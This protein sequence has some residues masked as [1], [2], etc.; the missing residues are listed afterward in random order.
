MNIVDETY[1][2]NP[3]VASK[4]KE[5][6]DLELIS[7]AEKI[8][9][10]KY[11]DINNFDKAIKRIKKWIV[12]NSTR[13]P[14][15]IKMLSDLIRK[16][17]NLSSLKDVESHFLQST[18]SF[19]STYITSPLD[20]RQVELRR[21]NIHI[22]SVIKQFNLQ[23]TAANVHDNIQDN[24]ARISGNIQDRI[25]EFHDN[26][27]D[28]L[29]RFHDG[30][31]ERRDARRQKKALEKRTLEQ[32]TKVNSSRERVNGNRA[33]EIIEKGEMDWLESLFWDNAK[34]AKEYL[35]RFP[36]GS[37]AKRNFIN[38]LVHFV[39]NDHTNIDVRTLITGAFQQG[40]VQVSRL[41]QLRTLTEN[42][43][44]NAKLK[45]TKRDKY[46]RRV[47]W[48]KE[49]KSIDSKNRWSTSKVSENLDGKDENLRD[50]VTSWSKIDTEIWSEWLT[51]KQAFV[52]LN[53][54]WIE[55]LHE[56]TDEELENKYNEWKN[57]RLNNIKQVLNYDDL[58][59]YATRKQIEFANFD[60]TTTQNYT[61]W[62]ERHPDINNDENKESQS[63]KKFLG[64]TQW[65]LV[66]ELVMNVDMNTSD[67]L[68]LLQI[69][70]MSTAKGLKLF[71]MDHITWEWNAETQYFL[72]TTLND[73]SFQASDT[74]WDYS[75]KILEILNSHPHLDTSYLDQ[76]FHT[77][78]EV[79]NREAEFLKNPD[80]FWQ[81]QT[82]E[83]PRE[84]VW[85]SDSWYRDSYKL[86]EQAFLNSHM[87]EFNGKLAE[88]LKIPQIKEW[89]PID[90]TS[91]TKM[92]QIW[93]TIPLDQINAIYNLFA[94]KPEEQEKFNNFL[95]DNNFQN[96]DIN[97]ISLKKLVLDQDYSF[98]P[99]AKYC[100]ERIW[101]S[102]Q[103]EITSESW[104]TLQY[105][106]DK[107]W[108]TALNIK[109][110]VLEFFLPGIS[111]RPEKAENGIFYFRDENNL[112]TLYSFDPENWEISQQGNI[113]LEDE[114]IISFRSWWS[115]GNLLQKIQWFQNIVD[116]DLPDV[117]PD[118][119]PGNMEELENQILNKI[120]SKIAVEK[121]ADTSVVSKELLR[122]KN[123]RNVCHDGIVWDLKQLLNIEDD[124]LY[125]TGWE[126]Y[127]IFYNL[128]KTFER[129]DVEYPN[130]NKPLISMKLLLDKIC[131]STNGFKLLKPSLLEN[132]WDSTEEIPQENTD[133]ETQN[134][135]ETARGA[136]IIKNLID[137]S[138]QLFDVNL[139]DDLANNSEIDQYLAERKFDR[140]I[141][142]IQKNKE[143]KIAK[144][145]YEK[146]IAKLYSDT[147]DELHWL[148][149][150][151]E[152][153][154][155]I[156]SLENE[157][158]FLS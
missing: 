79:Q 48:V 5:R 55:K 33:R 24:I 69:L 68:K 27:Q 66:W 60:L 156:N 75:R 87:Q 57:N 13:R 117:L 64:F 28:N 100:Y 1:R 89:N 105:L 109:N 56:I 155:N 34:I 147:H 126:N 141:G 114:W 37:E 67:W 46:G 102:C 101:I 129:I 20:I 51:L 31:V 93:N 10:E 146:E 30:I 144:E 91:R 118:K 6:K 62:L 76:Y 47:S 83:G 77:L 82:L 132:N 18:K 85:I 111:I 135:Q 152:L 70:S 71:D 97:D 119:N 81:S 43:D 23:Q 7:K 3:D 149:E 116:I 36:D 108:D 42:I 26:I 88:F 25:T 14:L 50:Y 59:D 148:N 41:R 143:L 74:T 115:K 98:N 40:A 19:K 38:T 2:E 39:E 134:P 139:I 90:E 49:S 72:E 54:N 125:E 52:I 133:S 84:F 104:K 16:N 21:I 73:Q 154:A 17:P 103:N 12:L 153:F 92:E 106:S 113:S 112:D 138:T 95:K 122:L 53:N 142:W 32:G 58:C 94:S 80:A 63:I 15:Y 96:I 4:E 136:R 44:E 29:T 110:K 150:D 123:E 9:F 8:L 131:D 22:I 65:E 11:K 99:I 145:N 140:V 128:L 107:T 124:Y 35:D 127:K 121:V 158:N 78:S 130:D 157:G 151:V 61:E 137:P 86:G 45:H 120:Q